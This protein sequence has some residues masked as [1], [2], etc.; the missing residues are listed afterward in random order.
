V[1]IPA[2]LHQLPWLAGVIQVSLSSLEE[3]A[4]MELVTGN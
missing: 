2:E 4:D 1:R 3:I